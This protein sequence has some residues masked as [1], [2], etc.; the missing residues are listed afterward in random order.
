MNR[1]EC[2]GFR[3]DTGPSLITMP[4]VF[5]ELFTS[6]GERISDHLDLHPIDPMAHYLFD[7]GKQ[8]RVDASMPQ[9]LSTLR[10]VEPRGDIHFLKMMRLGS[11]LYEL[12][13]HTF[14]RRSVAEPPDWETLAAL[15]HLP[16]RRAW[17]SYQ[18][19]IHSFFS[20]SYLRQLYKRFPT[21]VGASPRQI[22][23]TFT[24]IPYL[25]HAFGGWYV[26]G[27]LYVIIERLRELG[28]KRGVGYLSNQQ[29]TR[30]HTRSKRVE[31]IELA[32]GSVH[33][34][35]VAIFNGDA[36]ILPAL[37]GQPGTPPMPEEH[38]SLS[39]FVMLIG[40][41][42][43][44]STASHH[45]VCFSADYDNEFDDLFLRRRFPDDP[46]VYVCIPS[47]SDRSVVPP[48][49]ETLFIMANAP[50]NDHDLWD[51]SM[52]NTAK[53]RILSR[54]AKS[55]FPAFENEI[56]AQ[57]V[58]T[59]RTMAERYLMP[60]GAIYGNHSHGWRNAFF[61][62]PNKHKRIGGLY[63]VGGSTH[64]GGGTPTVLLSARIVSEMIRKYEG[65]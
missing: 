14:F 27:G 38:R 9:W 15:R 65:M 64:P 44:L 36:S 61:R 45:T 53:T 2:D 28:E 32:D 34:C 46:T 60:G 37:L 11:R 59:P 7:D 8:F 30:I 40:L 22:P 52:I 49:G 41:R 51:R 16:L 42:K 13:R 55:G 1:W 62:P 29:V 31:S 50:A 20:S 5:E 4:W 25:E 39:G 6:A 18:N 57:S 26:T 21:Y 3:F 56:A 10:E 24:L 58:L 33:P 54:L 35:S 47:H 17:G 43:R 23:A 12:S 48:D 19:T 63:C